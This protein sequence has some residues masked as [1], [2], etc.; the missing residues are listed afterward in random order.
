M[1]L[2]AVVTGATSG[3]G[4]AISLDLLTSG[5]RVLLVGRRG[6]LLSELE[7]QHT[8]LAVP[9]QADVSHPETATRAL[10]LLGPG[11]DDHVVVVNAAG[12]T[13]PIGPVGA[14]DL[15]WWRSST[16]T[17]LLGPVYFTE[18]FVPALA[19]ARS[20]RIINVSSAQAF[21]PPTAIVAAYATH[22]VAL[23]FYTQ[24]VADQLRGTNVAAVAIHP[25][26]VYTEIWDR[27]EAQAKA[28]GAEGE[29]LRD[30][31]AR[32]TQGGGDSLDL[33]VKLVRRILSAPADEINGTFQWVEGGVQEPPRER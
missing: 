22:K 5:Y 29:S 33:V 4:R 14:V 21:H 6:Q 7:R 23:N 16:E 8:G 28:M 3:V 31:V 18:T 12:E 1:A 9:L 10:E 11:A 15:A 13:G 27:I 2:L 19:R 30:V 32:I 25:G 24:C 17:N 20:G 26:D